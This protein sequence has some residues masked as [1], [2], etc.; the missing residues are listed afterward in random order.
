MIMMG[1]KFMGDVPFR[2]V[3]ITP[4]LRDAQGKKMSKSSG[5]AIDPLEII[6][7]YGADAL[8]FALGWLTVQGRDINLS[9]E[10]IEASRNFMNKLWN[11]SRFVLMNEE[12]F[13]AF[14]GLVDLDIKDRW[15]ISRFHRL[16]GEVEEALDSLDFGRYAQLLYDFVWGEYCDWYIEWSKIDLYQGGERKKRKA[17]NVLIYLLSGILKLLHPVVPFITEEIWQNLPVKERESI[18]IAPWPYKEEKWL[19]EEAEKTIYFL[20]DVI[21]EIRYLRAEL[22]IPPKE[23]CQVILNLS[24]EESYRYMKGNFSY[25]ESLAKCSILEAGY[26]LKKP[27]SVAT[28]RVQGAD[29]YLLVGGVIDLNKE[30][31]RLNKKLS[32]LQKEEERLR[33]RLNNFSFL[34]RAPEEVVEKEKKRF[35]DLIKEKE[36]LET[37]LEGI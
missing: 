18:M 22:G 37:L 4:L 3:Y 19:D 32:R 30:V 6:D 10:R 21:R 26:N 34:H 25:V 12:G 16:L 17:Q 11:V 5:N 33:E 31:E 24:D 29:I 35:A 9:R 7:Q 14:E 28:G 2:K 36:K 8:R 20:Q 1:L 13:S 23:E 15:I 27:E